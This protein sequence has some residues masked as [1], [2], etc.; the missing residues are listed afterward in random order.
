V[1]ET[2]KTTRVR[3]NL[4]ITERQPKPGDLMEF[5]NG[6][7]VRYHKGFDRFIVVEKK[8]NDERST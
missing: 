5:E 1:S 6:F 2:I 3:R 8:D 7:R 4:W